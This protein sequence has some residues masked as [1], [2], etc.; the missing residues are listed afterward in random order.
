MK[1]EY[2]WER[3]RAGIRITTRTRF[4]TGKVRNTETPD[5]NFHLLHLY[6]IQLHFP[7]R[8]TYT[9]VCSTAAALQTYGRRTRAIH[10][11][12]ICAPLD[13]KL[14]FMPLIPTP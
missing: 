1:H 3:E 14:A 4:G 5:R 8:L 6:P 11:T 9:A 13:L 12:V 2:E 10:S 7:T